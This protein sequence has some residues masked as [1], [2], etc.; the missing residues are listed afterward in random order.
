MKKYTAKNIREQRIS[1]GKL[2]EEQFEKLKVHFQ[3][4]YPDDNYESWGYEESH[5]SFRFY[6]NKTYNNYL[7]SY[8]RSYA[9]KDVPLEIRA[10]KEI[11][12]EE[13]DFELYTIQ[14]LAEGRVAVINDGTIE[15]LRRV[16]KEAFPSDNFYRST[17]DYNYYFRSYGCKNKWWCSSETNLPKQ[18]VKNFIMNQ[19]LKRKDILSLYNKFTCSEF[20]KVVEKYLKQSKYQ[21]DN[22]LVGIK[23]EDLDELYRRGSSEQKEAVRLLGIILKEDYPIDTPFFVREC[24]E[25][26]WQ[27][28]RYAGNGRFKSKHKDITNSWEYV[29][30][31]P[32]GFDIDELEDVVW[33]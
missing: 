20:N 7:Y 14:D 3:K 21:G 1:F 9:E 17:E 27:L 18:S 2:T 28:V 12:F 8:F 25:S 32:E 13:F 10:T 5:V 31:L 29:K 23:Q 22:D 15:E 16:L 26:N 6:G 24:E 19:T 4:L 30:K 11:S 33:E